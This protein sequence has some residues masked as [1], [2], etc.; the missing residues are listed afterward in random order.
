MSYVLADFG[1]ARRVDAGHSSSLERFSYRHAAPQVLDGELPTVADDVYSLGST[2]FTL[3]DGRPP[4]ASDD[5]DADTALAYL[6]RVRTEAPRHIRTSD[7][8]PELLAIIDRAWPN[9]VRTGTP[10]RPRCGTRSP[11][12]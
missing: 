8:P 10:T 9:G 7:A 4:F 6:R 5:P 11:P 12:S 1:L 2:L 3:L